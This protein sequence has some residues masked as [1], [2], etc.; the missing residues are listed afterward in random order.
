MV[1]TKNG[2]W[3]LLH[4]LT[5]EFNNSNVVQQVPYLNV[6]SSFKNLTSWSQNDV[7][8]WGSVTGFFPDSSRSWIYNN[9]D[10]GTAADA[11]TRGGT[12]IMATIGLGL[13]NNRSHL[14]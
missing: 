7:K 9:A 1:A 13:F 5:V 10:Y 12:N 14:M 3:Q 2:Y 11:G 8:D 4:S 6:F